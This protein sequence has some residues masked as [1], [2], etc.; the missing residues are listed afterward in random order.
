MPGQREPTLRWKL[1]RML[2]IILPYL[3][4]NV[5]DVEQGSSREMQFRRNVDVQ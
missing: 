1:A 5:M 4:A 3:L 2:S